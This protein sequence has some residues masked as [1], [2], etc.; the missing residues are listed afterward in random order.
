MEGEAS[1]SKVSDSGEVLDVTAD[2]Q[3]FDRHASL[4][5]NQIISYKASEDGTW[6]CLIGI[7]SNQA[8][9]GFKV[10]GAMQL[11][12][13]ERR[14]SQPIEGH[15]AVFAQ[16]KLDGAAN[17]TKL[18]AFASRTG[19]GAKVGGWIMVSCVALMP[20]PHRRDRPPSPQPSLPEESRRCLLPSRSTF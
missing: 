4:Q 2:A 1:P 11:Y 17:P 15:A 9:N 19:T 3:V 8:P 13:T 14:V 10:K 7:S 16:I 12:S 6:L 20:A 18:F 5:A